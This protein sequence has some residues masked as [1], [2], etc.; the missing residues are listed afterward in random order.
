M[1]AIPM[2]LREAAPLVRRDALARPA[3]FNATQRTI[4]A[5]IATATPVQR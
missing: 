5:V 2:F 4:E 3:S 1:N